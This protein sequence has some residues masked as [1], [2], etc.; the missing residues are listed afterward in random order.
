M[1]GWH[2]YFV[3]LL[4]TKIVLFHF[5]YGDT[6]F[7]H[8]TSPLSHP[9]HHHTTWITLIMGSSQSAPVRQ[10]VNT[11][12]QFGYHPATVFKFFIVIGI[13][14]GVAIITLAIWRHK[15]AL[16]DSAPL[17][18]AKVLQKATQQ[19]A[20]IEYARTHSPPQPAAMMPPPPPPP[21]FAT[22]NWNL[23]AIG[24]LPSNY[25]TPIRNGNLVP[26]LTPY[27]NQC[28]SIHNG[29]NGL[30]SQFHFVAHQNP[31]WKHG[32]QLD[33]NF[34]A[35]SPCRCSKHLRTPSPPAYHV[36]TIVG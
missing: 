12:E 9:N 8:R 35:D 13:I 24:F 2:K 16:D 25:P 4:P 18:A 15:K 31:Q 3:T 22:V 26:T 11:I 23:G 29:N 14:A 36:R 30:V 27:P 20:Y 1:L 5:L 19:D 6:H 7:H 34:A 32:N 17:R 21:S 33:A 28:A 10:V